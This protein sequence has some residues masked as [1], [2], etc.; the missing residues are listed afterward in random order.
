MTTATKAPSKNGSSKLPAVF[1]SAQVNFLQQS[2]PSEAI[3]TRKGRG[4]KELSYVKQAYVTRTLNEVFGFDWD[5]DVLWEQIGKGEVIVKGR[6]TVRT[7]SGVT[8]SKTQ[9]GGS[10][11]KRAK[12]EGKPFSVGDDLKAAASDALKKCASLLG[13]GLDLYEAKASNWIR[14]TYADDSNG[15]TREHDQEA[16]F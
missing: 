10:A 3:F 8:I 16:P 6:L 12:D 7:P 11:I 13:I 15:H 9:F 4:N 2:T 1:S 14:E 5:F